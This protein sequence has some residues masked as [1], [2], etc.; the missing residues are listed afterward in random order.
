MESRVNLTPKDR[1]FCDDLRFAIAQLE[2]QALNKKSTL[3]IKNLADVYAIFGYGSDDIVDQRD[4]IVMFTKIRQEMMTVL[5]Q[6]TTKGKYANAIVLRDRLRTIK[7][8]F[9]QLQ[10]KYEKRRQDGENNLFSE[11]IE[12]VRD[13]HEKKWFAKQKDIEAECNV[14]RQELE[15]TQLVQ[16]R[17]LEDFLDRLPDPHCKFSKTLLELKNS[18]YYLSKLQLFEQA[19]NVYTRADAMETTEKDKCASEHHR[20]KQKMRDDLKAQHE[21]ERQQLE[22]VLT[23]KKYGGVRA[24]DCDTK[25]APRTHYRETSS[26]Y[27]G[28]HFLSSVRGARLQVQSLCALHDSE[29]GSPTPSGSTVYH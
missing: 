3:E 10:H 17:Q 6:M 9:I 2:P 28:Q 15:K 8:D 13:Q 19:K 18:E 26:S 29:E 7:R 22:E 20:A 23:E 14:R 5:N 1:A 25:S 12:L 16:T 21:I 24:Q 4:Q 27:G 11:A